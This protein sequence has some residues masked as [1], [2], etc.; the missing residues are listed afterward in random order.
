MT[1]INGFI[2]RLATL[3]LE[4]CFN[5]YSDTCSV[6]DR[7]R[8][9]AIRKKNLLRIFGSLESAAEI[10]IWVGRDLGYRGGRR[11]GLA[12]TDEY[13]LE[14]YASHLRLSR[15]ER[16][17][18]GPVVKERTAANIFQILT[19]VDIPILTWN[20]FPLH[21]HEN[22][23]PFT[24]RQHTKS[25]AEVGFTFL[26]E[27]CSIFPVRRM[28]AIGNDAATWAQRLKVSNLH[29]RHPSYGGQST[30]LA[31]MRDIYGLF[32][33]DEAQADLFQ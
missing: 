31:Q 18:S 27:L 32:S 13:S 30:F 1:P 4:D 16:A 3:N 14:L 2:E 11:T 7:E 33:P 29:V 17:T 8:A 20:V 10:D 15:L 19:Q 24:N 6:F 26:D 21:P 5:P 22:G 9:P 23:K 28:V 12:L 25:E